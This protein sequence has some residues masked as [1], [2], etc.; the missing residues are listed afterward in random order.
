MVEARYTVKEMANLCGV[1]VQSIYNLL[2]GNEELAGLCEASGQKIKGS[3]VYGRDVLEWLLKYYEKPPETAGEPPAAIDEETV[4]AS[5]KEAVEAK[6]AEIE[7]LKQEIAASREQA[8]KLEADL[9]AAQETIGRVDAERQAAN[10]LAKDL[11]EQNGHLLLLLGEAQKEVK[12]L[13]APKQSIFQRIKQH[14]TK[15]T[16]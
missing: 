14:F 6:E 9:K 5:I 3:M 12:L 15:T 4:A 13:A 16:E 1:S 10:A 7:A 11:T 2:K 8:A